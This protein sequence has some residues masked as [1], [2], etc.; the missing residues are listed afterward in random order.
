[1]SREASSL[2]AVTLLA[3][4]MPSAQAGRLHHLVRGYIEQTAKVEWPMMARQKA[5]LGPLLLP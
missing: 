5:S 1:M 2:R 3:A 4:G